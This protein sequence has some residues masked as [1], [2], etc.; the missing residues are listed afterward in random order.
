MKLI[1]LVP[2]L[3]AATICCGQTMS[4]LTDPEVSI[5]KTLKDDA[6]DRWIYDDIVRG[7]TEA[8]K[9]TKPLLI[10]VRCVP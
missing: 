1:L 3:L 4:P 9:Q 7:F 10:N 8:K 6:D 2:I 5:A